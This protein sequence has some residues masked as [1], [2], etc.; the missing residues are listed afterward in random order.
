[1]TMI[2][3]FDDIDGISGEYEH[4]SQAYKDML[5]SQNFIIP[6]GLLIDTFQFSVPNTGALLL[7]GSPSSG[8]QEFVD[9]F[10]SIIRLRGSQLSSTEA[11]NSVLGSSAGYIGSERASQFIRT[12]SETSNHDPVL[13]DGISSCKQ[14]LLSDFVSQIRAG[15]II[16]KTGTVGEVDVSN[17]VFIFTLYD[18]IKSEAA[19][20]ES[21]FRE[22][23]SKLFKSDNSPQV[24]AELLDF[25]KPVHFYNILDRV[26]TVHDFLLHTL[27]SSTPTRFRQAISTFN[28]S[29]REIFRIGCAP[30]YITREKEQCTLHVSGQNFRTIRTLGAECFARFQEALHQYQGQDEATEMFQ[31]ALALKIQSPTVRPASLFCVGPPGIGK[32]EL[33]KKLGKALGGFCRIDSNVIRASS[34]LYGTPYTPGLLAKTL[35]KGEPS[36]ILFDEIE[37]MPVETQLSLLQLLD[38]GRMYD[39][40][41]RETWSLSE[42]LIVFTSNSIR[43]PNISSQEAREVLRS[44]FPEEFIDRLDFVVPFR[45]FTIEHKLEIAAELAEAKGLKLSREEL[46]KA[47]APDSIR[48]IQ[49]EVQNLSARRAREA[50]SLKSTSTRAR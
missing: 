17:R 14:E 47:A 31:D 2:D 22:K 15:K 12:L 20:S 35:V 18:D 7:V 3:D 46:M 21:S 8:I 26:D 5:T 10:K 50:L 23:L 32:T 44:R 48:Q 37:K 4:R 34:D 29:N 40:Y 25:A 13:I 39:A 45:H 6:R 28:L 30:T 24:P 19:L 42:C 9:S 33:A 27:K 16:D 41:S 36:V 1:M 38:E 43:D 11:Y 49:L